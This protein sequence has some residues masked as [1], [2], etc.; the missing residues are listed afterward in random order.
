MLRLTPFL[1]LGLTTACTFVTPAPP[2]VDIGAFND[3]TL[4]VNALPATDADDLPTG[5]VEYTGQFGS[6]AFVDGQDGHALIGDME[7]TVA[8]DD[9]TVDGTFDNVVLI[10][11]GADNAAVGGTLDIAGFETEGAI[12][13]TASGTLAFDDGF[14]TAESDM[15]LFLNGDVLNDLF[16][17]DAVGGELTGSG[18][19]DVDVLLDGNGSWYGTAD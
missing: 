11:D 5:S 12:A 17:G 10:T 13:A 14:E 16:A 18:S 8:F 2:E 9:A 19:G 3:E 1:A 6:N 7:M 4:R 15:V